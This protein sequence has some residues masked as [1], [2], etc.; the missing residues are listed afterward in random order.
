MND[1]AEPVARAG[2]KSKRR[3]IREAEALLEILHPMLGFLFSPPP[4]FFPLEHSWVFNQIFCLCE[5]DKQRIKIKTPSTLLCCYWV[6]SGDAFQSQRSDKTF[7]TGSFKATLLLRGHRRYGRLHT[8]VQTCR[9]W[10]KRR[11]KKK[12]PKYAME[13]TKG[14]LLKNAVSVVFPPHVQWFAAVGQCFSKGNL[15]R[16]RSR[17]LLR[18]TSAPSWSIRQFLAPSYSPLPCATLPPSLLPCSSSPL[19]GVSLPLLA[20]VG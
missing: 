5:Q 17:S 3:I 7:I 1:G 10:R 11:K 12:E 4:Q 20:S 9:L 19:N 15:P 18:G 16:P 6:E 8:G 14:K 13:L 2:N